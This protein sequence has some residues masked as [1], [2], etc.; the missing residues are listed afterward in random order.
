[1]LGRALTYK[2]GRKDW[3]KMVPFSCER[4]IS[5]EP[6]SSKNTVF[7]TLNASPFS[8]IFCL[9]MHVYTVIFECPHPPPQD[10]YLCVRSR[11]SDSI[12]N[13]TQETQYINFHIIIVHCFSL[14]KIKFIFY[15]VNSG[16]ILLWIHQ[17]NPIII[18]KYKTRISYKENL[19]PLIK[20]LLG[21]KAQA[22]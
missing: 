21:L 14:T 7:D 16:T 18:K 22:I 9:V 12:S 2:S 11:Q 4:Q 15:A 17:L 13:K 20:I 10:M 19:L 1:M 6:F 3:E 5:K 8:H